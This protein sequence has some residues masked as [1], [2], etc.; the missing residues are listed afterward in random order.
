MGDPTMMGVRPGPN[1]AY[2]LP[3]NLA[4]Q[5]WGS[6]ATTTAYPGIFLLSTFERTEGGIRSEAEVLGGPGSTP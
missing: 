4:R 1:L 6:L 5:N 2:P 3:G